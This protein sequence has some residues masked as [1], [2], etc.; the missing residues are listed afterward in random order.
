MGEHSMDWLLGVAIGVV[1]GLILV[2]VI[3]KVTKSDGKVRCEYD[4]RQLLAR[5]R[6]WLLGFVTLCICNV[7]YAGTAELGIGLPAAPSLVIL[8]MILASMMVSIVYFI[9]HDAYFGLNE[10][11]GRVMI[12]FIVIALFNLAIGLIS[13]F[14]GSA[15]RDGRLTLESINLFCAGLFVVVILA[16]LLKRAVGEDDG[17]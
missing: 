8:I 14:N 9:W 6:G 1:L 17:E 5:G 3:L 13:V 7:L 15:F 4:E 16:L 10:K 2:T 11:R 12:A